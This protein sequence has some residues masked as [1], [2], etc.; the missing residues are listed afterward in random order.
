MARTANKDQP[1]KTVTLPIEEAIHPVIGLQNTI[2]Y[3]QSG[4]KYAGQPLVN[5]FPFASSSTDLVTGVT[6]PTY[7]VTGSGMWD[8][9]SNKTLMLVKSHTSIYLYSFVSGVAPALI[10][11]LTCDAANSE[12]YLETVYG[13]TEKASITG[14]TKYVFLNLPGEAWV[15]AYNTR[16]GS[17][18]T[19]KLSNT[20]STWASATNYSLGDR[21]IPTVS[22]GYYYEVSA[23]AGS[24][25]ATEPTWPTTLGDTVVDSGITWICRGRYAGFPTTTSSS[26]QILDGYIFVCVGG[27]IYNS[28]LDL[29]DS[30]PTSNFISTETNPDNLVALAKYKNY[31]V[32]FGTNTIEF[33]YDAANTNGSPLARQEGIQHNIGCIGQGAVT[34]L[35]DRIFWIAQSGSTYYSIW[36]LDNFKVKKVSSSEFDNLLTNNL[37]NTTTLYPEVEQYQLLFLSRIAG[38]FVL[39]IPVCMKITSTPVHYDTCY[40]IDLETNIVST[41]STVSNSLVLSRPFTYKSFYFWTTTS[42]AFPGNQ[43]VTFTILT[44]YGYDSSFVSSSSISE[45]FVSLTSVGTKRLN[46]GINNYKVLNEVQVNIFPGTP[47]DSI[48]WTIQRDQEYTLSSF[49]PIGG[50]RTTRGGRAREFTCTFH[51]SAGSTSGYPISMITFKYTEHNN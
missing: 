40:F 36:E 21:R 3:E 30:W 32:A 51:S 17:W 24:S 48:Y 14:F 10:T 47:S 34:Q 25:G 50:Y 8:L 41:C 15:V 9:D 29:P 6:V 2:L 31:I 16:I 49:I 44:V 11:T 39:G 1:Q 12:V 42:L 22:N 45:L 28:D 20:Y 37:I 23:D 5:V 4:V 35:E 43:Y 19:A 46:F 33:F 13:S 38:K 26:V 18:Q 27:D 7:R